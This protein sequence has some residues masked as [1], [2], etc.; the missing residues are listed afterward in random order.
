MGC[1]RYNPVQ[2]LVIAFAR[3]TAGRNPLARVI[4]ITR[5]ASTAIGG[6]RRDERCGQQPE[7]FASGARNLSARR[8]GSA[9]DRQGA[10]CRGRRS[11]M[12]NRRA[13]ILSQD[14]VPLPS[15][16][17]ERIPLGGKPTMSQVA[18]AT[19]MPAEQ[20]GHRVRVFAV[21]PGASDRNLL[22]AFAI[23]RI[24]S[25]GECRVNLGRQR[26]RPPDLNRPSAG[27]RRPSTRLRAA[28]RPRAPAL[29]PWA[30]PRGAAP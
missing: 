19:S 8:G 4:T 6:W 22:D 29:A 17:P 28:A 9:I 26:K 16:A 18:E 3:G 24:V 5:G 20:L 27:S 30:G 11:K 10:R 15:P 23:A 1:V 12:R 7:L 21:A 2:C 14:D 13:A 25:T